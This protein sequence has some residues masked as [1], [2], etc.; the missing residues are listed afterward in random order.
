MTS[1]AIKDICNEFLNSPSSPNAFIEPFFDDKN[2]IEKTSNV[3]I[4]IGKTFSLEKEGVWF[5]PEGEDCKDHDN[6]SGTINRINNK[7]ILIH[8]YKG[9]KIF[10]WISNDG[11][12]FDNT[13][14]TIVP[15]NTTIEKNQNAFLHVYEDQENK[16]IALFKGWSRRRKVDKDANTGLRHHEFINN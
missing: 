9:T 16:F 13:R 6:C 10:G 14:H 7:I 15:K 8:S 12:V 11:L 4:E 5:P 3:S 2:I 1:P